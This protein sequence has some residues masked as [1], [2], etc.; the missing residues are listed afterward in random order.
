MAVRA[1]IVN[2]GVGCS[3]RNRTRNDSNL[4]RE[5][6]LLPSLKWSVSYIQNERDQFSHLLAARRVRLLF[7]VAQAGMSAS[8]RFSGGRREALLSLGTLKTK[9]QFGG[10]QARRWLP[11]AV[12]RQNSRTQPPVA[13]RRVDRALEPGGCPISRLATE[14][15]VCGVLKMAFWGFGSETKI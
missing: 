10:V 15:C 6:A 2:C 9:Q 11:C 1:W 12:L 5:E 7:K 3:R 14:K 4:T 13:E 8:F